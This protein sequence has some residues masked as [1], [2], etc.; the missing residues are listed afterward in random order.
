MDWGQQNLIQI[1]EG[2]HNFPKRAQ[3]IPCPDSLTSQG[4]SASLLPFTAPWEVNLGGEV[5]VQRKLCAKSSSRGFKSLIIGF[6]LALFLL[7]LQ[8]LQ[9]PGNEQQTCACQPWLKLL[10]ACGHFT[11]C[12]PFTGAQ[13]ET[14]A[15]QEKFHW[16]PNVIN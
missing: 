2:W 7:V 12:A 15:S 1:I 16:A 8:N 4:L 5:L 11:H 9:S 6:A 3:V 14:A 13:V 10:S